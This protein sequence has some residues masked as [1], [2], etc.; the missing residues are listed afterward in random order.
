[1]S[2]LGKKCF[3]ASTGTHL[4]L[5]IVLVVSPAF[6]SKE[7]K[8]I[9]PPMTVIDGA[10]LAT[11]MN[12]GAT[13]QQQPTPTPPAPKPPTPKPPEPKREVKKETPKPPVKK[14]DPKPDPKPVE[15]PK[16]KEVAKPKPKPVVK[17]TTPKPRVTKPKVSKPKPKP[18]TPSKIKVASLDNLIR[19]SQSSAE[20]KRQEAEARRQHEAATQAELE[21]KRRVAQA[22]SGVKFSSTVSVRASAGSSRATMDYG[23]Y[24]RQTY[25]RQWREPSQ[26][27][28]SRHSADV[29]VTIR[30]NGSVASARLSRRSGVGALDSS[31]QSLIDRVRK[32][33][34][35]PTGMNESQA[36][37]TIE[38]SVSAK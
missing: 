28:G 34:P 2:R 25:D 6:R 24:V 12:A 17:R 21:G 16:P 5:L 26:L 33:R 15:K 38:F 11:I 3:I 29:T 13:P 19:P 30:K 20:K 22:F 9:K 4:L 32:F 35:F 31:I 18:K 23:S 36:T 8:P 7:D 37:F 1:M 27:A 14:P 10:K